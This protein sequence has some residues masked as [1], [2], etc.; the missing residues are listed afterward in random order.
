M[1]E[2]EKAKYR[3]RYPRV[4]Q[5]GK[6]I[7]AEYP[8]STWKRVLEGTYLGVPDAPVVWFWDDKGVIEHLDKVLAHQRANPHVEG[9]D[10]VELPL[11][12][13]DVG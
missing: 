6:S 7:M 13:H 2:D 10:D 9:A 8:A 4:Q 12:P 5:W 3:Q 1:S 11:F